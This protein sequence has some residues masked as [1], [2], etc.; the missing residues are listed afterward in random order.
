MDYYKVIGVEDSA[1][2]D[3]NGYSDQ[4]NHSLNVTIPKG[5]VSGRQLRLSDNGDAGNGRVENLYLEIEIMPRA[6][7][8]PEGRTLRQFLS[9]APCDLAL[10]SVVQVPTADGAVKLSISETAKSGQKLRVKGKGVSGNPA[11][12]VLVILKLE[13]PEVDTEE[14]REVFELVRT[15][16]YSEVVRRQTTC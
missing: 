13:F 10:G 1:S 5:V 15:R 11:G 4:K 7:F 6:Q 9:V 2:T 12:D 16:F 8:T 3:V 14:Q